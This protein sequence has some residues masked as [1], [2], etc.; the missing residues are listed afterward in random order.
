M[1]DVRPPQFQIFLCGDGCVGQTSLIE[2]Y[3]TGNFT[4]YSPATIGCI[5]KDIQVPGMGIAQLC[6]VD[7]GPPE[8]YTCLP[9]IEYQRADVVLVCFSIASPESIDNALNI[10]LQDVRS[11]RPDVPV[12]LV[13]CK[14][15][16]RDFDVIEN[17][18]SRGY[19]RSISFDEGMI[20]A[21]KMGAVCYFECSS[22]LG[23]G[24]D[25]L[26]KVAAC[27][28]AGYPIEEETKE[29]TKEK[30][31]KGSKCVVF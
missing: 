19:Q 9:P 8:V 13:G 17:L 2:R 12:I 16:L 31:R 25:K 7:T 5:T 24:V 3:T 20:Y 29:K 4:E 18:E 1:T 21:L 26:F 22:M 10:W 30:K 27:L 23:K 28:A 11:Q 14:S 15:D 6:L